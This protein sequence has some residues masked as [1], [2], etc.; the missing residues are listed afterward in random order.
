[1]QVSELCLQ[2]PTVPMSRAP[3]GL[4]TLKCH[5][6]LFTDGEWFSGWHIFLKPTYEFSLAP[7]DLS[8]G[9]SLDLDAYS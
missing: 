1:M 5:P 8:L 3:P 4:Q 2:S 6:S 9:S 7:L